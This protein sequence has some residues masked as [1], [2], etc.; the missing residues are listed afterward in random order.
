M[1]LFTIIILF[2]KKF[3]IAAP[4]GLLII[5]I[6]QYSVNI[7]KNLNIAKLKTLKSM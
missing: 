3:L 5:I 6:I 1:N 4:Q 7:I 2:V